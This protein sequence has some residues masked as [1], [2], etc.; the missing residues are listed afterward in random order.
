MNE[1][2]KKFSG[3]WKIVIAC[4][5]IQAIPYGVIANLQ[6]QFMHYVVSDKTLGFSMASFS[7]IFTL[8]TIVSAVGSP[9]IGG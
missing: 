5:L 6:P 1:N 8:G 7:L 2:K 4:M 9:I 3:G